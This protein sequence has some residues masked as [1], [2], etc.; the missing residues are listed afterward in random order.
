ML[1]IASSR[2]LELKKICSW[3]SFYCEKLKVNAFYISQSWN[4]TFEGLNY[5][6]IN[7]TT[8]CNPTEFKNQTNLMK[9]LKIKKE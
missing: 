5:Y 8:N 4:V 6:L 3:D 9:A 1:C 7:E 2:C